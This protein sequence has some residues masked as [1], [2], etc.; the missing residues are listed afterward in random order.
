MLRPILFVDTAD[1][2]QSAIEALKHH[3]CVIFL[4]NCTSSDSYIKNCLTLNEKLSTDISI[5]F[6]LRSG[7]SPQDAA[8]EGKLEK[9]LFGFA[10]EN[11]VEQVSEF[12]DAN[13]KPIQTVPLAP[14]EEKTGM[15]RVVEALECNM[16]SNMVKKAPPVPAGKLKKMGHEPGKVSAVAPEKEGHETGKA[17]PKPGKKEEEEQKETFDPTKDYE[18]DLDD[19]EGLMQELM[20]VRE[21]YGPSFCVWQMR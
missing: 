5:L 16:W 3:E 21:Q 7:K 13:S 11:I 20:K 14:G 17:G 8:F 2:V 15:A 12:L 19:F 6:Y 10:G 4:A 9:L 1:N 18:K